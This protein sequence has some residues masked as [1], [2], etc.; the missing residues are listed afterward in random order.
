LT[1]GLRDVSSR[2]QCLQPC[3]QILDSRLTSAEFVWSDDDDK[4]DSQFICIFH[5]PG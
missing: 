3:L 5:L 1:N 4:A 2:H